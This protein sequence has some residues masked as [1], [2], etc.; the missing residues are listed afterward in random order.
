MM[1]SKYG[2][3]LNIKKGGTHELKG[4]IVTI[5]TFKD[6]DIELTRERI[7]STIWKIE[8]GQFKALPDKFKCANCELRSYNLCPYAV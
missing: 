5:Y 2:L 8:T 1:G 3:N 6:S 4:N 7:K